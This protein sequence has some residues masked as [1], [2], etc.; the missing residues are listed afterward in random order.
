MV[1]R[2]LFI[3]STALTAAAILTACKGNQA[4]SQAAGKASEGFLSEAKGA[5]KVGDT[6]VAWLKDNLND[7]VMTHD[8]FDQPEALVK[9][10]GLEAGYPAST[11][12][13]IA[14]SEG[15]LVLFD[16][17]NGN[18]D[19]QLL[20][21]LSKLG[22]Q[23]SDIN[24]IAITH[25]HGDHLGGLTKDGSAV[26]PNAELYI[27]RTEF[28]AFLAMEE[29]RSAGIKKIQQAYKDRIHLI[30]FGDKIPGGFTALDCKGHTPGHTAF[31]KGKAVIVGDVMHGVALQL[32]H[33]EYCATFDMDKTNAV[34]NRKKIIEDAKSNHQ[35]LFG[36]HFPA[37]GYLKF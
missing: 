23:P 3:K 2:R 34:A 22:I 25:A 11:S 15:A 16:A 26:F 33:P 1:T 28:D 18:A 17:G 14:E 24:A 37:P 5:I 36:A 13:F 20:Y 8:R 12:A 29:N 31:L 27:A 10:L 6:H 19:S 4:S 21:E 30:E 9:E 32:E 35:V 7:R